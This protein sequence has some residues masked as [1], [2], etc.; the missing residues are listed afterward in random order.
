MLFYSLDLKNRLEAVVREERWFPRANEFPLLHKSANIF[1]K[2][3]KH[4]VLNIFLVS[5]QEYIVYLNNH[6]V[7]IAKCIYYN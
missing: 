3:T 5:S 1:S 4:T 7:I 2:G 6:V